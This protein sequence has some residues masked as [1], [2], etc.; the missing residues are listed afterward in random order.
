MK[1]AIKTFCVCL[2]AV[3][4]LYGSVG[5]KVKSK[6]LGKTN[7][8]TASLAIDPDGFPHVAYQGTDYSLYH[9]RFNGRK[10]VRELVD[11]NQYYENSMAI[12]SQGRI[13]IVY[14]AE[15]IKQSG[16]TYPLMYARYDGNAWH[17]S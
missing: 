17:V 5:A 2:A 10:W 9:A 14:G 8:T 3:L 6:N 13:H 16:A 12:D 1:T 15:R 7:Q 11:T 4:M